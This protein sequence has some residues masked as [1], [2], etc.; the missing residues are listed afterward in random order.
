MI[1]AA[2]RLIALVDSSKFGKVDLFAF[3]KI[4]QISHLYT[5]EGI[6][7]GWIAALKEAGLPFSVCGKNSVVEY[8]PESI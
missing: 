6:E 8:S 2:G 1:Q 3:A 7:D 5:D 4:S